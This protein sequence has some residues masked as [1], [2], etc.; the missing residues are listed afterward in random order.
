MT[1]E[2]ETA[3][4]A[5][6]FDSL[7]SYAKV[8]KE[9]G[10]SPTTAAKY[11]RQGK[12]DA[13]IAEGARIDAILAEQAAAAP[14][15]AETQV[16]RLAAAKAE[17]EALRTWEAGDQTTD[18]P[19]TP[20]YDLLDPS[21]KSNRP[22]AKKASGSTRTPK[23]GGHRFTLD[24]EVLSDGYQSLGSVSWHDL[25]HGGFK[26]TKTRH[27]AK[28][29]KAE[30]AAAGVADPNATGWEVELSPGVRFGAIAVEG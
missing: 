18:R 7:G 24:G 10:I 11:A 6:L 22:T 19:A 28:A 13:E 26:V 4:A 23:V 3:R 12:V 5:R 25:V 21:R 29:L 1:T 16:D 2:T 27:T 30:L 9:M 20:N 14:K 15:V 8:A 17:F